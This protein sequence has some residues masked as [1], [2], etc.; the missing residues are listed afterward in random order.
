MGRVQQIRWQLSLVLTRWQRSWGPHGSQGSQGCVNTANACSA[1]NSTW[2]RWVSYSSLSLLN[3]CIMFS[4]TCITAYFEHA[5]CWKR[6]SMWDL[7]QEGEK[8]MVS[9][10]AP[11]HTP[12]S[13]P[14]KVIKITAMQQKFFGFNFPPVSSLYLINAIFNIPVNLGKNFWWN[15]WTLHIIS[16]T[17]ELLCKLYSVVMYNPCNLTLCNRVPTCSLII[18]LMSGLSTFTSN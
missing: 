10:A 2:N 9:E 17:Q 5:H 14:Q 7:W 18:L 1:T 12:W 4:F 8:Q 11:C 13:S 15:G 3:N 16:L 6:A